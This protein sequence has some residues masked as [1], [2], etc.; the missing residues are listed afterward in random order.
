MGQFQV[1]TLTKKVGIDQSDVGFLANNIPTRIEIYQ[2]YLLY[3][4]L[5]AH[6]EPPRAYIV[7]GDRFLQWPPPSFQFF[8]FNSAH[9]QINFQLSPVLS[10]I[11]AI[12]GL[13]G[14]AHG[15]SLRQGSSGRPLW[16]VWSTRHSSWR[17]GGTG[18]EGGDGLP[19]KMSYLKLV[20]CGCWRSKKK[21]QLGHLQAMYISQIQTRLQHI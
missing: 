12:A 21:I 15:K 1:G 13:T 7:L 18:E 8:C 17:W 16:Q 6:I 14:A 4:F 2:V 10:Q 11:M 5:F 3:K 19:P 20:E 9:S